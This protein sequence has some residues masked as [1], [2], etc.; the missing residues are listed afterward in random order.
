MTRRKNFGL[1][2]KNWTLL[3]KQAKHRAAWRCEHCG[4]QFNPNTNT[5]PDHTRTDGLPLVL[6]VHHLDGDPSNNQWTNLL[7][8]CQ[9]CHLHIQGLWYP[10]WPLPLV[11]SAPPKWLLD[12]DL[13]YYIQL[14]LPAFEDRPTPPTQTKPARS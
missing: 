4:I 5:A 13:P 8:C 12:R 6:T 3:A 10:G 1:Y 11:W 14:R 9:R 2:P 7:S